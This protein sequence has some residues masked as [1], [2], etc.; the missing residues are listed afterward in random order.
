[1]STSTAASMRQPWAALAALILLLA[2]TVGWLA[3]QSRWFGKRLAISTSRGFFHALIAYFQC[4]AVL[5]GLSWL[6][7]S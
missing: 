2:A 7:A 5:I 3:I 1:M 6:V 4:L